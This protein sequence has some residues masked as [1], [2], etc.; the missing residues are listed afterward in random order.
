L[1]IAADISKTWKAQFDARIR[2]GGKQS[3][4]PSFF[5]TGKPQTG[6]K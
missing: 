2:D 6:F 3:E 1:T 5:L 4:N